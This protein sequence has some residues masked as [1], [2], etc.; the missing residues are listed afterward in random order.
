[1]NTYL[2]VAALIISGCINIW[3]GRRIKALFDLIRLLDQ[4][5]AAHAAT[6][7]VQASKEPAEDIKQRCRGR[8]QGYEHAR[9]M[10]GNMFELRD[11]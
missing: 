9:I 7:K 2:L 5:Y 6:A 8:Q 10:L 4:I 11:E 1:M 3:A